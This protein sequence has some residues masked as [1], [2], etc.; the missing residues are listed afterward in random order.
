MFFLEPEDAHVMKGFSRIVDAFETARTRPSLLVAAPMVS[1]SD[2]IYSVYHSRGI[3][4]ERRDSVITSAIVGAINGADNTCKHSSVF[5]PWIQI[6][7]I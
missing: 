3:S 7:V 4:E 2:Q 1:Y 5:T 6:H